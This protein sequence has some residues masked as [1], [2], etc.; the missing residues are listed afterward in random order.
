VTRGD[1]VS[2]IRAGGIIAAGEGS[3]LKRDGWNVPKP[4][5]EVAGAPLVEHVIRNFEAAGITSVAIIF[6]EEGEDCAAFVR[7][8]FS[9]LDLNVLLRTTPS[10]LVSFFEVLRLAAPGRV[11][12]STV[13]AFLSSEDF[14][15][16]VRAAETLD[17]EA[18]VVGVTPFVAD[19]KPLRA[20]V[21]SN[22]RI[23]ELGGR[24]GDLVTAGLY[25]IP[26]RFRGLPLPA[27]PRLRDFLRSLVESGETLLGVP[28]RKVVDVDRAEDVALAEEMSNGRSRTGGPA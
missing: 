27:L 25:V 4:L 13:D 14:T 18:V 10:S 17:E 7:S 8:R 20:S 24:E 26:S 1:A 28:I 3:R 6:N 22:G 23:R 15:A 19:E 11:L 9:R 2:P 16:F 21:D 5:V 12:V